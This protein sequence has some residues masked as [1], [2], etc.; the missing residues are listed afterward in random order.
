MHLETILNAIK[1]EV[2]E[3]K[4]RSFDD[5]L[6]RVS[7]GGLQSRALCKLI[8]ENE[9]YMGAYLAQRKEMLND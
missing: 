2:R 6:E 7:T 3:D 8:K 1:D 9:K 5:V 4:S